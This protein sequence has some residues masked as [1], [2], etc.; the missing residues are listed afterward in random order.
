MDGSAPWRTNVVPV[1]VAG[2]V[3][4]QQR[5]LIVV[6]DAAHEVLVAD[7]LLVE[8]PLGLPAQQ[9]GRAGEDDDQAVAGVD[10]L[11][12][13]AG[14]VGG[15]AALDIA[16]DQALG[17][18]GLVALRVAEALDDAGGVEVERGDGVLVPAACGQVVAVVL[19]VERIALAH[20]A[21]VPG[22]ELAADHDG[23]VGRHRHGARRSC[24][25]LVVELQ[26]ARRSAD[27]AR[28]CAAPCR[29]P[30]PSVSAS[31]VA[32]VSRSLVSRRSPMVAAAM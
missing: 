21:A 20:H 25:E 32:R 10:R 23:V 17:L 13:D 11:G 8:A 29:R 4:G 27:A 1:R 30:A 14:E 2:V 3:D 12:D 7:E 18:V 6:V 22:L 28:R 24:D 31:Q 5:F 15:L 19:P 9:V 26:R 16:D